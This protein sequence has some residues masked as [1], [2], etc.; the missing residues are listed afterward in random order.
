[1]IIKLRKPE[2]VQVGFFDRNA[3]LVYKPILAIVEKEQVAKSDEITFIVLVTIFLLLF[4]ARS[5]AVFLVL[6]ISELIIG[7]FELIKL[8]KERRE[9]TMKRRRILRD[10]KNFLINLLLGGAK[11][12]W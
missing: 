7:L 9:K 8:Y 4:F 11:V 10:I 12:K 6:L 2:L 3:K 5:L 1:M